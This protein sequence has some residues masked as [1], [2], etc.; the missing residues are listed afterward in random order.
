MMND[1]QQINRLQSNRNLFV[2]T[3]ETY[4]GMPLIKKYRPYIV[5]YLDSLDTTIQS[6]L[7]DHARVIAIRLDLHLPICYTKPDSICVS[8]IS[9]FIDSFKAMVKSLKERT[10]QQ[11]KR[12]HDTEVHYSWVREVGDRFNNEHFHLVIY[13]NGQTFKALGAI[14]IAAPGLY[15][16]V[17]RAW[18]SA[19]KLSLSEGRGLVHV[20]DYCTYELRRDQPYSELFTRVSYF[21]KVNTKEYHDGKHAFGCSRPSRALLQTL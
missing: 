5:N 14:D 10:K 17:S 8:V 12:F 4:R 20:P 13:L 21:A 16:I 9:R 7:A 18:A 6:A 19:L 2:T 15:G 11:G 1:T 3:E